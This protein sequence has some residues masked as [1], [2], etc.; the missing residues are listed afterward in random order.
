MGIEKVE[1]RKAADEY[2]SMMLMA[3]C[4]V[5]HWRMRLKRGMGSADG[6]LNCGINRSCFDDES[7]SLMCG[8]YLHLHCEARGSTPLFAVN[9]VSFARCAVAVYTIRIRDNKMIKIRSLID[10]LAPD[11]LRSE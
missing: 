1:R 6:Y 11:R 2:S 9:R 3:S 5:V 10:A 4:A 7:R 8:G